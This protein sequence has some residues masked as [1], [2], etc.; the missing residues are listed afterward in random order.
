[1]KLDSTR[2]CAIACMA[3]LARLDFIV[4]DNIGG[5]FMIGLTVA[6]IVLEAKDWIKPNDPQ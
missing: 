6:A 2:L 4:A 3:N 5:S 1:M